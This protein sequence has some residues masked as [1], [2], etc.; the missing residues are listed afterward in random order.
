MGHAEDLFLHGQASQPL[1]HG[2][3]RP[4]PDAGI[5]LVEDDGRRKARF[6]LA[7]AYQQH[8]QGE[9]H[10]RQLASR[11]DPRER[12]RLLAGVGGEQ[13]LDQI[14]PVRAQGDH[15]AVPHGRARLLPPCSEQHPQARLLE[16]QPGQLRLELPGEPLG[17]LVTGR[18]QA[19]SQI[20]VHRRRLLERPPRSLDRLLIRIE[21]SDLFL[22]TQ[23]M[24]GK[25]VRPAA[26]LPAECLKER[27]ARFDGIQPQG[28]CLETSPDPRSGSCILDRIERL[29]EPLGEARA[30]WVE[31]CQF[32]ERPA[33]AADPLHRRSLPLGQELLHLGGKTRDSR[34]VGQAAALLQKLGLLALARIGRGELP[35]LE[36]KQLL[37]RCP[38][39]Q[40][41]LRPLQPLRCLPR[42]HARGGDLIAEGGDAGKAVE[43][44]EMGPGL[45]ERSALVLSVQV[46]EKLPDVT[47]SGKRHPSSPDE[48]AALP[49]GSRFAAQEDRPFFRLG[50][51]GLGR[52]DRGS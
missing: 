6:R 3:G 30:G 9:H 43:R 22:D 49:L 29:G 12:A 34:G 41:P 33:S 45:Q 8:I 28:V 27:Q 25:G 52:G 7:A 47:E 36:A 31:P 32:I 18:T 48:R 20:N 19:R 42:P 15:L 4:S 11:R 37:F 26:V 39:L 40:P 44:G 24:P 5:H 51:E 2:L 38:A 23:A 14:E 17:R 46:D 10:S 21:P 1:P 13:Q 16:G 50:S 35:L